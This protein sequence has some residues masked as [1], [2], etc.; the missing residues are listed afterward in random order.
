MSRLGG[1]ILLLS[2]F[3]VSLFSYA[4]TSCQV[5]MEYTVQMAGKSHEIFLEL[6]EGQEGEFTCELY[7]LY[8][9]KVVSSRSINIRKNQVQ[10]VFTRV[11][12]SLY[13]I[14]IKSN[15]CSRPVSI[16]GREGINVGVT[17]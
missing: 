9:G 13:T 8:Q 15:Q 6:K 16:G 12:A 7:D 2:G 10:K 17:E 5:K 1:F 3:C 11:S 4:Q 14:Y